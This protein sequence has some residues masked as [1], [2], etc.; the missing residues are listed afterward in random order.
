MLIVW[1]LA[2]VVLALT[3]LDLGASAQ[4]AP[5]TRSDSLFR[6]WAAVGAAP[7]NLPGLQRPLATRHTRSVSRQT[8]DDPPS[9]L[10]LRETPGLPAHLRRTLVRYLTNESPGTLVIDTRNTYLY[11]VLGQGEALRYGIGVGRDGFRWA[12]RERITHMAEWPDWRAPAEMLYRNPDLPIFVPG[13]LNNPLG[14]RALYLGKTL[15]RIHGTNEPSTIG[16]Y[17]TSGCIRLRNEDVIDLYRRVKIGAEVVV[18][19]ANS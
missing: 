12:G 15:Y 7:S 18:L 3:A 1:H 11:L 6:P 16:S 19:A 5:H 14:A 17:E 4:G 13:G 8:Y 2:A 9:A 10:V